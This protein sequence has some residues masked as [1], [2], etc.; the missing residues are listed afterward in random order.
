MMYTKLYMNVYYYIH[1]ICV[2]HR[3]I[4]EKLCIY[5]YNYNLHEHVVIFYLIFLA[6]TRAQN[7]MCQGKGWLDDQRSGR[8]KRCYMY[9]ITRLGP[10]RWRCTTFMHMYIMLSYMYMYMNHQGYTR[11]PIFA[12][13]GDLEPLFRENFC[14]NILALMM[15]ESGWCSV[16]SGCVHP[17]CSDVT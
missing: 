12:Y 7:C 15:T 11:A 9:V 16:I 3:L 2:V 1:C 5:E 6:N 8:V 4:N 17:W 13:F 10:V 14:L